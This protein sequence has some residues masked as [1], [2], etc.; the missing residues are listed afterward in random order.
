ML[1]RSAGVIVFTLPPRPL[2]FFTAVPGPTIRPKRR[3]SKWIGKCKPPPV[4]PPSVDPC[5]VSTAGRLDTGPAPAALLSAIDQ[6]RRLS[7]WWGYSRAELAAL[8]PST[9]PML[10][11]LHRSQR[12]VNIDAAGSGSAE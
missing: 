5:A 4:G 11:S 8:A 6:W 12:W 2:E 1:Y 10:R 7:H 3:H 9:G